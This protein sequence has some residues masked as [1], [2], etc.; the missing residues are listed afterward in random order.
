MP[1][2]RVIVWAAVTTLAFALTVRLRPPLPAAAS[3]ALSPTHLAQLVK[4]LLEPASAPPSQP[5]LPGASRSPTVSSSAPQAR[6][7]ASAANDGPAL[8]A[9]VAASAA[10]EESEP[11]LADHAAAPIDLAARLRLRG[12]A[13]LPEPLALIE[14]R[15]TSQLRTYAPS[16]RV[17]DAHLAAVGEGS[18]WLARGDTLIHLQLADTPTPDGPDTATWQAGSDAAASSDGPAALNGQRDAP[19][20]GPAI[21]VPSPSGR[22]ALHLRPHQARDG[23]FAGLA[24]EAPDAPA[25]LTRLG[26]REGDVLRAINGQRLTSPQQT[27]QLLRKAARQPHLALTLERD[28]QPRTLQLPLTRP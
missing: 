10:A 27:L 6:P 28:G 8:E 9:S 24:V 25:W 16:E 12:T 7:I 15:Q 20:G 14:D 3:T 4:R 18:A 23:T 26:A 19:T 17:L 2:L 5:S 13:H 21:V 11:E 22:S 1:S